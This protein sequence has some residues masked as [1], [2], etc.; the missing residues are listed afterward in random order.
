MPSLR[1][2]R[3][4]SEQLQAMEH[5]LVSMEAT[6]QAVDDAKAENVLTNVCGA[7]AQALCDDIKEKAEELKGMMEGALPLLKGCLD[8]HTGVGQ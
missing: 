1:E 2:I 5:E 8:S 4:A 6:I 3:L 7:Q